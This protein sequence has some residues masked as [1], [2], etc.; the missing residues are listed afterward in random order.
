MFVVGSE[1]A[2]NVLETL[3]LILLENWLSI[4]YALECYLE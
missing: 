1:L 3:L 2:V 4:L